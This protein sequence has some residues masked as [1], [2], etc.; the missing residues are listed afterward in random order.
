MPVEFK[1]VVKV[2]HQSAKVQHLKVAPFN[3]G[4]TGGAQLDP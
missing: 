1:H 4:V 3:A 2:A